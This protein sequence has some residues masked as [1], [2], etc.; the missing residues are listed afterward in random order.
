[1][2]LL[3]AGLECAAIA[4]I[5][6][7]ASPTDSVYG[8]ALGCLASVAYTDARLQV[9]MPASLS[10]SEACTLPIV[11]CTAFL[12]L[13]EVAQIRARQRV[14]IHATSGGVGLAALEFAY[15]H[16]SI[17]SGSVGRPAKLAYLR[18]CGV[19]CIAS[20]RNVQAF[21]TGSAI[22]LA[23]AR[24]QSVCSALSQAFIS[25]SLVLLNGSGLYL[26]VSTLE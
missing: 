24:L 21:I 1:V 4:S 7:T 20:T 25:A 10:F 6:S 23:S 5:Q 26:E 14:L 17:V 18:S 8:L 15:R 3:S 12:A 19:A 9:R 2:S 13:G 22:C 11:C 16:Y